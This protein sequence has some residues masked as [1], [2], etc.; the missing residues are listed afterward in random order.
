EFCN[1]LSIDGT[2]EV[3]P[4]KVLE[5]IEHSLK[6]KERQRRFMNLADTGSM[7]EAFI[8]PVIQLWK[9]QFES[10]CSIR[11]AGPGSKGK[12]KKQEP[13][14]ETEQLEKLLESIRSYSL[15]L[16]PEIDY[17]NNSIDSIDSIDSSSGS[18]SSNNKSAVKITV[19]DPAIITTLQQAQRQAQQYGYTMGLLTNPLLIKVVESLLVFA[20]TLVQSPYV[21]AALSE[22][23]GGSDDLPLRDSP[24]PS[25]PPK[26]L[27]IDDSPDAESRPITRTTIRQTSE[28]ASAQ[29]SSP[30]NA[31][32]SEESSRSTRSFKGEKTSK[33]WKKSH[34]LPF[35]NNVITV[36]DIWKEWNH[37][38]DGAD[39]IK[40]MIEKSGRA[41]Y[42]S[43]I[44]YANHYA[45][46][47]GK[48][49]IVAEIK[50]AV[51]GG[52]YL[53][54]VLAKMERFRNGRMASSISTMGLEDW[55]NGPPPRRGVARQQ[56]VEQQLEMQ[57]EADMEEDDSSIIISDSDTT[58]TATV[59][60]RRTRSVPLRFSQ[61][62]GQA[63]T[64]A[65]LKRRCRVASVV[66]S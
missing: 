26:V 65:S 18:S 7:I 3:T 13:D 61:R 12:E 54:E 47:K 1:H 50:K 52:E 43:G 16:D 23:W 40:S 8:E 59:I 62:Q 46:M 39:S 48:E 32:S 24:N 44:G 20:Q 42:I 49:K 4:D 14:L 64:S 63:L 51:A 37:G 38:I 33:S 45:M 60:N 30:S 34:V 6:L 9:N 55:R 41:V 57:Q 17:H 58:T 22:Q 21:Y 56:S 35:N 29:T 10:S 53:D 36:A 28:Q 11:G 66:S 19:L 31:S 25:G 27:R 15:L 5:Y 2:E